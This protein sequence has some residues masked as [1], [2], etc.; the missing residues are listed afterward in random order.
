MGRRKLCARG[1]RNTL[2]ILFVVTLAG[3]V[4]AQELR[5]PLDQLSAQEIEQAVTILQQSGNLPPSTR[6][7]LIELNEAPKAQVKTDLA[8]GTMHRAA[9]LLMYDWGSATASEAVVDLGSR[10]I[11]SQKILE[12]REPPSFWL[13]FAR[14]EEIVR[15]D[16]RWRPAMERR[17]IT[18][19]EGVRMAPQ[20]TGGFPP[21]LVDAGSNTGVI[22]VST[23]I[24][25]P[26][27]REAEELYLDIDVDLGRGA[28]T[29]F[30][31]RLPPEVPRGTDFFRPNDRRPPLK[32]LSIEQHAGPSFEVR[33]SKLRWQNW[34]LRFGVH[35]RRG[36]DLY[37]VAYRD[38]DRLRTVL[39][40]ASVS[41]MVAPY[42]D[43]EW[44]SFY[45][46]DEGGRG[47]ARSGTLRPAEHGEDTPPNTVYYPAVTH[48]SR[49]NSIEIPK[50]ISIYER[51]DGLLWRHHDE[52]RRARALVL[53]T[54]HTVD[55]YD[56]QLSWVFR[57]DGTI[58]VEAVLTG[59]IN[60]YATGRQRDAR[61]DIDGSSSSH[62]LVAP[63]VVGPIHQHFFSYRLDLDV[64]GER[65]S[66]V[67]L[68]TASIPQSKR[69]S[70]EWFATRTTVLK[71]ERDARREIEMASSRWWKIINPEVVTELGQHPGYGLRP[72]HNTMPHAGPRSAVRRRFG[73][74]DHHLWVTA[75]SPDEIY[76]A[77]HLVGVDYVG[78][79][80]PRWVQANRE[81]ANRD[82]VV[83]Y[84]LGVTHLPRPEDWP[85]MPAHRAG[86]AL[87]PFGFFTQ[88]PAMDVPRPH[89]WN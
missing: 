52:A 54:F 19:D 37:D 59:V 7:G 60:S 16:P 24:N 30:E 35:P 77:G 44:R 85:I 89:P 78:E 57:M 23:W 45:P 39:Y 17:G 8:N 40:R 13:I 67:E 2:G 34:E 61:S 55:N 41:E 46:P 76:A 80:L 50:A 25:N 47:L 10:R 84:T 9:H 72:G 86:F 6:F 29:K 87:I 74:I 75:Y 69:S 62:V 3:I 18:D 28:V 42:G 22:A 51:D 82:V 33:G 63:R 31:D 49:G 56:Y 48:D 70:D 65:N 15:A 71:R 21:R 88:N 11:V 81:I 12:S 1:W 27:S 20:L 32:P 53:T 5:H 43:P 83:W 38:G 79:G 66:V 26:R 64:E 14:I 4:R 36:L 73:F 58:E 68:N